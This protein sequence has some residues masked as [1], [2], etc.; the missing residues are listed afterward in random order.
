MGILF[1]LHEWAR[2]GQSHL[3]RGAVLLPTSVYTEPVKDGKDRVSGMLA[4]LK[5][6]DN[7]ALNFAELHLTETALTPAGEA[8]RNIFDRGPEKRI[9]WGRKEGT[10][11]KTDIGASGRDRL[12]LDRQPA[13]GS[14]LL[15]QQTFP[16]T[17]FLQAFCLKPATKELKSLDASHWTPVLGLFTELQFYE[18]PSWPGPLWASASRLL[19]WLARGAGCLVR[20][21]YLFVLRVLSAQ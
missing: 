6:Y 10:E 17:Q 13:P 14:I 19:P 8:G 11:R 5:K 3:L 20:R 9:V 15:F 7:H 1:L 21:M 12:R 18:S 2:L 4:C 16:E